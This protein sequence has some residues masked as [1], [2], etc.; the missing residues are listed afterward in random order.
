MT[1]EQVNQDLKRIREYYDLVRISQNNAHVTAS[2]GKALAETY[3]ALLYDMPTKLI[4]VY[5]MMYR[6]G[7]SQRSAGVAS[8]RSKSTAC[9][10]HQELVAYFA[11]HLPDTGGDP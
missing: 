7:C 9:R 10:W 8:N 2:K 3:E 11:A 1:K 4:W 6:E 5:E